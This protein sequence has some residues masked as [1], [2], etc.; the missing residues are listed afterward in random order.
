MRRSERLPLLDRQVQIDRDPDLLGIYPVDTGHDFQVFL[1]A[2][3]AWLSDALVD[4][5]MCGMFAAF[6]FLMGTGLMTSCA[7]GRGDYIGGR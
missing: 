2:A 5:A 7:A 6:M 1:A 3:S 4:M